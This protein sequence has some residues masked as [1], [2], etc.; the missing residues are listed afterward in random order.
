[1]TAP[2]RTP[3]GGR[4]DRHTEYQFTFAGRTLTGHPGDTLASALLAHGLH[5]IGSSVKYGR[6]RGISAAWAEDTSGLV[7]IDAPFSEPM[8][9]ASTVELFD[10]LVARGIPGQGRLAEVPDPARYDAMH[11]H[12][13]LLVIGAGPAGLLAARIRHTRCRDT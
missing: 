1:M 13:D 8:L 10:G 7:Q 3:A 9:L 5:H 6:P 4:I 11:A 12:A 2:Y